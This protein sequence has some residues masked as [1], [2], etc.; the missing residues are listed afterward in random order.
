MTFNIVSKLKYVTSIRKN[1]FPD[2]KEKQK[3]FMRDWRTEFDGVVSWGK[4]KSEDFEVGYD[5]KWG[6]TT[7]ALWRYYK[8]HL[9]NWETGDVLNW[10]EKYI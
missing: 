10:T 3:Y 7:D 2:I 6:R 5:K 8:L 9:G 4:L 1:L